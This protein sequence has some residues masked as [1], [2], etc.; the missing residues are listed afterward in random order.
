MVERLA[1]AAPEI[2]GR[3]IERAQLGELNACVALLPR[4]APPAGRDPIAGFRL[5]PLT[6]AEQIGAAVSRVCRAVAAGDLTPDQGMD[7]A[8]LLELRLRTLEAIDLATRMDELRARL[9]ALSEA[10]A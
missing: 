10:A 2:I 1:E 5:G 3:L 9:E 8:R 6:T 7:L 4:I